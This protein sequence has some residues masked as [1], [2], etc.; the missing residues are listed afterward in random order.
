MRC[1]IN[2]FD[3]SDAHVDRDTSKVVGRNRR[4]LTEQ[5]RSMI[6]E[7]GDLDELHKKK[8]IKGPYLRRKKKN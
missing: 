7:L 3:N 5:K 6:D 4:K 8:N 2:T 1:N